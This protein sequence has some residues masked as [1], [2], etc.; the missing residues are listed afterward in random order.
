MS[1]HAKGFDTRI[2]PTK[3][4]DILTLNMEF[5]DRRKAKRMSRSLLRMFFMNHV[6]VEYTAFYGEK[7]LP[8]T[9][10]MTPSRAAVLNKKF[11][12]RFLRQLDD[13][14]ERARLS[15]WKQTNGEEVTSHLR[16]FIDRFIGLGIVWSPVVGPRKLTREEVHFCLDWLRGEGL[17]VV[18]KEHDQKS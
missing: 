6:R 5:R 18:H 14:D 16:K 3:V 17:D 15:M 4:R 1:K 13:G 7:K 11:R 8:K 10:V 12:R 9:L 2:Q